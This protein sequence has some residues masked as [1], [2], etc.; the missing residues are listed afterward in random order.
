MAIIEPEYMELTKD[1]DIEKFWE[2]NSLCAGFHTE[3]PRCSLSF[4]PDDHWLFE[5]MN[6]PSTLRYYQ[7]KA[8]RDQLIRRRTASPGSMSVRHSSMRIPGYPAPS[9]LKISFVVNLPIKKA[10]LPG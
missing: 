8:Y 2:E 9:G 4:S 10:G 1:F 5:F 3:K 6:V 7:D